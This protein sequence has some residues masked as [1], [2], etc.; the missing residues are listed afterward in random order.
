MLILFR[1]NRPQLFR[2]PVWLDW[3]ALGE[4]IR[5]CGAEI[6]F[7]LNVEPKK[8][9]EWSK[10]QVQSCL[11]VYHS[12]FSQDYFCFLL[13]QQQKEK[14]IYGCIDYIRCHKLFRFK[15]FAAQL[16]NRILGNFF[17]PNFTN[18][19]EHSFYDWA[20]KIIFQGLR[21]Y[22]DGT[23]SCKTHSI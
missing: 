7:K 22:T 15:T 23:L 5:R 6:G 20:G 18:P 8:L 9:L 10:M 14:Q 1:Q 11:V 17:F 13:T 2:L 21:R 12:D 19:E 4:E 16:N 3:D